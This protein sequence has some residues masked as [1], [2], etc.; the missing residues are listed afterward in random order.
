MTEFGNRLH[1]E[2]LKM[3]LIQL[4]EG[5]EFFKTRC[6]H[7]TV[8]S[9]KFPRMF[10]SD[11]VIKDI[12]DRIDNTNSNSMKYE[13]LH[14]LFL[15]LV[16][17]RFVFLSDLL[18]F[19][20]RK[21]FLLP[22]EVKNCCDTSTL[23]IQKTIDAILDTIRLT[24]LR[25]QQKTN[26]LESSGCRLN[27]RRIP[28]RYNDY[29]EK[30]SV[31]TETT[32]HWLQIVDGK[33]EAYHRTY[34]EAVRTPGM[35]FAC[36]SKEDKFIQTV[37]Q[38]HLLGTVAFK[39][40]RSVRA[41]KN[42]LVTFGHFMDKVNLPSELTPKSRETVEMLHDF[43]KVPISTYGILL[44][45]FQSDLKRLEQCINSQR[46]TI[47]SL[48]IRLKDQENKLD[49]V[50]L[51]LKTKEDEIE[52]MKSEMKKDL[53]VAVS[54]KQY[55]AC[56]VT[57]LRVQAER[58]N[59]VNEDNNRTICSIRSKLERY[60]TLKRVLIQHFQNP[61]KKFHTMD[62]PTNDLGRCVQKLLVRQAKSQQKIRDLSKTVQLKREQKKNT[63]TQ[64]VNMQ[65]KH[66]K[67]IDHAECLL[68][69]NMRQQSKIEENG[70]LLKKL[71]KVVGE[72]ETDRFN[73]ET[74]CRKHEIC[75]KKLQE[76]TAELSQQEIKF[77]H[78]FDGLTDKLN[79]CEEKMEN[80]IQYPH[81][82][83]TV[84]TENNMSGSA[85]LSEIHEKIKA[86]EMR[87]TLLIEQNVRLRNAKSK[88]EED[89]ED[90]RK[91]AALSPPLKTRTGI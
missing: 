66:Q 27:Q 67:L 73:L 6:D 74:S 5:I 45:T 41:F 42:L 75:Q 88:L 85:L 56:L 90:V 78:Q 81:L 8:Y 34:H 61:A 19:W 59:A 62:M 70:I 28:H 84:Y 40:S 1:I 65:T 14:V 71:N 72:L 64:L 43:N 30:L 38:S 55:L 23:C 18:N 58:R 51:A 4:Q 87:I 16:V 83:E 53:D 91:Q 49:A 32:K 44:E 29:P 54:E 7:F 76:E 82:K 9:W 77:K 20:M 69:E 52:L 63:E 15:E 68:K 22:N 11:I 12:F 36:I 57:E 37:D 2:L 3:E 39:E 21:T 79:G 89:N 17:D 46:G 60:E 86:N 47:D 24:E 10:A 31:I 80:L 50:H 48:R 25:F 26:D 13:L 33:Y 35:S